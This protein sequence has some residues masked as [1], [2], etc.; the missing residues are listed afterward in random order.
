MHHTNYLILESNHIGVGSFRHLAKEIETLLS[1]NSDLQAQLTLGMSLAEAYRRTGN[2]NDAETVLRRCRTMALVNGLEHE[3]GWILWAHANF[4]RQ[5]DHNRESV[6]LLVEAKRLARRQKDYT[7]YTYCSAGIAEWL[8]I[9]GDYKIS[10]ALHEQCR[11]FFIELGDPRGVVWA[12]QG[13]AQMRMKRQD[14][15]DAYQG[16]MRARLISEDIGDTRSLA[17]SLK[18]IAETMSRIGNRDGAV[19]LL[20]KARRLFHRIDLNVGEGYTLKSLGD[21]ETQRTNFE[22]AK[23]YYL[24]ADGLFVSSRHQRGRAYVSLGLG[25]MFSEIEERAAGRRLLEKAENQFNLLNIKSGKLEVKREL[26][27]AI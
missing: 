10:Y 8:R 26:C 18:G 13:M 23:E 14:L 19:E 17:Y 21:V 16:F 15:R 25:R 20:H 1:Q 3:L 7:L 11:N 12:I 24:L 4:L 2:L 22:L 6:A 9:R 27:A 5:I